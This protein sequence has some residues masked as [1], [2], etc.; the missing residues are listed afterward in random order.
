MKESEKTEYKRYTTENPEGMV[1]G[2]RNFCF[3]KNG[4][5]WLRDLN[6]EGDISL[7]N[8]C[9]KLYKEQFDTELECDDPGEFG[10]YMD[11]DDLISIFYW[12]CCGF[13]EVREKLKY[14]EDE[15]DKVA[16]EGK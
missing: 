10:D 4:E 12:T 5:A 15:I 13:A 9:K 11:G 1:E 8:Y 14:H 3:I 7:I 6:G 16:K 2:F